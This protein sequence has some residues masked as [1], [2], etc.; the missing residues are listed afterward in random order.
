M[1]LSLAD[2][3][4]L[5]GTGDTFLGIFGKGYSCKVLGLCIVR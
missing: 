1:G 3:I 5:P 2:T 4:G